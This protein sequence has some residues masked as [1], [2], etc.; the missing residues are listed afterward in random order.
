MTI[1]VSVVT[2]F[3]SRPSLSQGPLGFITP[4]N[5]TATPVDHLQRILLLYYRL[6]SANGGLSRRF[7]WPLQ[8]LA[9]LLQSSHT[10]FGVRYLVVQ[11]YALHARM[12]EA[13]RDQ[14]SQDVLGPLGVEDCL[15]RYGEKLV[16]GAAEVEWVDGWLLS[17]TESERIANYRASLLQATFP[18]AP[19]ISYSLQPRHLSPRIVNLGHILM[20]RD[21]IL[22]P[23]ATPL[24][25]TS[26]SQSALHSIALNLSRRVPILITAPPGSGKSLLIQHLST[27]LHDPAHKNHVLTIHLSDTSLD[28][29]T[30]LGSYISST[31]LPGTFE[32]IEGALV[33]AMKAGKWVVL[34]DIDKSSTELLGT[35]MP[36]IESLGVMKGIGQ[37]ATME[38]PGRGKVEAAEGFRLFA[39]RSVRSSTPQTTDIFFP[40]ATFLGHHHWVEIQSPM[41][42]RE[43]QE[44]IL[45]SRFSN[46]TGPRLTALLTIWEEMRRGMESSAGKGALGGATAR[47]MGMRDLEKWIQRINGLIPPPRSQDLL[48]D[49]GSITSVF[50]NPSLREDIFLETRDVFFGSLSPSNSTFAA[51]ILPISALLGLSDDHTQSLLTSRNPEYEVEVNPSDGR[52]VAVRIGRTRLTPRS[53][54]FFTSPSP[55]SRPFALHRPS[56][57]LLERLAACIHF[58]EPA[59]LV[60]ET[61]TGKTTS[62]QHLSLLLHPHNQSSES[63]IVINLS[64]QTE[65]ADLLGGF[66]PLDPRIPAVE[67]QQTFVS[68]FDTSFSKRRNGEFLDILRKSVMGS[69]WKKVVAMWREGIKRYRDVQ[70]KEKQQRYVI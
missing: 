54:T 68:L 30:L 47:E 63:L 64:N 46:V 43:E 1:Y 52:T 45:G 16:D 32:W 27:I 49:D 15:V 17:I 6:L 58:S 36:L 8:P 25:N 33:R 35:L 42:S 48:M 40:P 57:V 5:I 34:K 62:I 69:K 19:S 22:L 18:F 59:L 38:V 23:P 39:T 44:F 37:P 66:K 61:G 12:P 26:T 41:P 2:N 9:Y 50:P 20:Y 70:Q 10:S 67:L 4:G 11:C 3:L 31:T 60:G 14:L 29:K 7:H 56:L 28:P 53:A 65:S 55:S 13:E 24:V 21:T 51:R